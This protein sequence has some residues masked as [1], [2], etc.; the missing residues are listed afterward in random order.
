MGLGN[1]FPGLRPERWFDVRSYLRHRH[2][3]H[4]CIGDDRP[5]ARVVRHD[6]RPV[7][8]PVEPERPG[9]RYGRRRLRSGQ[10]QRDAQRQ[11]TGRRGHGSRQ[12][13]LQGCEGRM[14]PRRREPRC[15]WGGGWSPKPEY[16]YTALGKADQTATA[17]TAANLA[18]VGIPGVGT[19][20]SANANQSF[21]TTDNIVRVGLNYK[22]GSY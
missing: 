20:L 16:L 21:R 6:A 4:S 8:F 10:G 9:L 7:G 19:V 3:P 11:R 12:R 18:V 14:D 2:R 22:W 15:P 1:R 17:T 13:Y 5:Q